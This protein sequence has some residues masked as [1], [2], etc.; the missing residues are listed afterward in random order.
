M[1]A[2]FDGVVERVNEAEL[3]EAKAD[4]DRAGVAVCPNSGVALAGLRK[5][6]EAGTIGPRKRSSSSSSHGLKYSQVGVEYHT[7]ELP[8]VPTAHENAPVSLSAQL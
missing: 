4:A 6:R 7:N 8:G 2:R 3:M 1:V 5:L